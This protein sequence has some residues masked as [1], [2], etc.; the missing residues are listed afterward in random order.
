MPGLEGPKV[1]DGGSGPRMSVWTELSLVP[2]VTA[3]GAL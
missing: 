1:T 3:V 2:V